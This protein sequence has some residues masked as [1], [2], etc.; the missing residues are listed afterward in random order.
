ML[1]VEEKNPLEGPSL[2]TR[3]KKIFSLVTISFFI[4]FCAAIFWFVGR[5]MVRFISEPSIF[6][7]WVDSHGFWGRLA[8]AGM[9]V[10]QIVIAIIPGEPLEIAAGYTFGVVEGTLLCLAGSVLGSLIVF[11]FVRR[12]GIRAVEVFFP[13]EK[14][15]SLKFIQNSRRLN[16]LVFILFFIPGTPKDIMTYFVPFTPMKLSTWLLIS[17]TARIPSIITSTIGGDALGLQNY[18][19]AIIAFAVT[20]TLSLG[21]VLLYRHISRK[22]K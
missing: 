16:L 20:L 2:S 8:F 12:F 14:L 3:K 5:P 1:A 10:V 15:L 17:A 4:L 13:R 7:A 6:R 9:M 11:L 19:F 21:G 22:R 18:L